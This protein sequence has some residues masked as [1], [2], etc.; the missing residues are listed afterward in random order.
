MKTIWHLSFTL[1]LSISAWA[2]FEQ[3]QIIDE[4]V[5]GITKIITADLNNNGFQDIITS[6]KYHD[7]HKISYFLN[8]GQESFEPQIILTTNVFIPEGVAAGDLNG[9][10]WIDIVG[11]SRDSNSVYW[12]PNNSGSFPV[13]ISLDTELSHPEDVEIFD[14]DNDGHP[15]IVVLDHSKIV[16]YYN[17]GT[18]SFTKVIVPNT[19]FEYYAFTIADIDGDGFKDI[20]IGSGDILVYM[21]DNGQ[22]TTHD[23]ARTASIVNPGLSFM[24]HTA[25]LDGNSSMDLIIDG[26]AG[27][28]IRWYANDGNGF[29][30]LMQTIENTDLCHSV[31][32]A[33][34][35]NN[36]NP[37]VFAALFQEGEVVWYENTGQGVFGSTQLV[38][39]GNAPRT[40]ATA[41][42]DL[43]ND[44]TM[45][46]IWAHPFSFH[47][48]TTTLSVDTPT[49]KPTITVYPNPVRDR[50]SIDS[51][52]SATLTV[53]DALGK[54]WISNYTIQKGANTLLLPQIPQVYFLRFATEDGVLVKRVLVRGE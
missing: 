7:N 9:N 50:L 30:T 11:I 5:V 27:S 6:Q 14:V 20:I 25:D 17:D 48:N 34:F 1:F 3:Q 13:E 19:Q 33:D 52:A 10:G 53:F 54:T 49:T 22:F 40:V 51:P 43:N 16:V 31:S 44:G 24:V 41:T 26:N 47:L 46:V 29:F 23:P 21:N 42:A 39:T 38:S 12:F 28:E 32:T 8:T 45:D 37:D 36:G 4:D 15:D 2:Q 35:N 18:G